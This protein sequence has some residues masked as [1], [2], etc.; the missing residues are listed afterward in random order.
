MTPLLFTVAGS[1]AAAAAS[2]VEVEEAAEL[3][4]LVADGL[5]LL[6][7]EQPAVMRARAT[8]AIPAMTAFDLVPDGMVVLLLVGDR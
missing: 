5:L 7:L 6:L 3:P 1:S 8:P 2:T 4:P